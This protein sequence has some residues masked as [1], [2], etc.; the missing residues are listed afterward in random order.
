MTFTLPKT[1]KAL[2]TVQTESVIP[3]ELNDVDVDRMLTRILEMAVKRGRTAASKTDTKA[4]AHFLD[5]LA[6]NRW[7]VG[8]ADE[9][10][11]EI[12]DGW[13][14]SAI[15]KEERTGI[16]RD[17]VQM[18]YLRPLTLVGYRSGL[19]KQA[20]R[21]R[22]ADILTYQAIERVLR[23]SGTENP[24][25]VIE[26]LFSDTFGRGV[27]VG[28]S[29]WPD[30]RYDERTEVDIDTLLTL[31]FLEGFEAS[32]KH[33]NERQPLDP[34]V[35]AAVDPLG[36]DIVHLLQLYGPRMPAAEAYS[37]LS[38]II[39]LRLFE[40]PLITA[41]TVRALLTGDPLPANGNPAQLYADFTRRR[42]T[43]SD[44]LSAQSVVR[45]LEIMRNFFRDRLLIRSL[46][47]AAASFETP[48]RFD[49][50]A[51][52]NLAA[53][54][55]LQHSAEAGLVLRMELK[56]IQDELEEGTDG[57]DF[58]KTIREST[59]SSTEKFI[60]VL[61][62]GLRKRGLENQV[63]WFHNAGGIT[64]PYG[65]LSGS[66]KHRTT[67][68][69]SPSDEALTT[70]LCLCFVEPDGSRTTLR[71]PIQKVLER[72]DERFGILIDRPPVDF[73]SADARAG[74]AENL[75]AFTGRLKLLG[76]FQG[77]SDDFNAQFVTRPREALR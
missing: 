77:L 36:H 38:A 3:V 4:Y 32:Q 76:C 44:T 27:D 70:M 58:V 14:R 72:L 12:L 47:D 61:V 28:V 40:L 7:M 31:R 29:P 13:V 10:G 68:R 22:K 48:P 52:E 35:P 53:V 51:A 9:R 18:G 75:A 50:T 73:D 19:P 69:Y 49:G 11:G 67:W 8:F 20:S 46:K 2:N 30:P 6:H 24:T 25:A 34:P 66:Q 65:I 16:R 15:L 63:K 64:K 45:D 74:A 41:R 57:H 26:R 23:L 59:L 43:A 37:H 62:E 60:Q 42:G 71:L 17:S 54:I 56:R 55:G 33:S 21:N 39:S 1:L 5:E